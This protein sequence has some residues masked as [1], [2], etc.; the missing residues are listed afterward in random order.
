LYRD[1]FIYNNDN[2]IYY[3]NRGE[4]TV[5]H[6]SILIL[7]LLLI[8]GPAA[9]LDAVTLRVAVASSNQYITADGQDSATI[10]VTVTDSVGTEI[11]NAG[12]VLTITAPWSL[13][14]TLGATKNDGTFTTTFL[15]TSVSGNA[16]ITAIATGTTSSGIFTSTASYDQVIVGSEPAKSLSFYS[17]AS[18]V[19]S[20]T[21]ITVLVLD[22]SGNPVSS[23]KKVQ[24]VVFNTSA[25][26]DSSLV[27]TL[28]KNVK[29]LSVPLNESGYAAVD[30][31]LST[32]P[33]MNYISVLPP[34][35]L[36]EQLITI[37]GIPNAAPA[38]ITQKVT[39][40]GSPPT[41][42]TGTTSY[43][44]IDYRL[45][46]QW[47]NPSA[48]QN[49]SITVNTGEKMM[50]RSNSD[51][52]ASIGYGPKKS[53]GLYLITAQ[54]VNNPALIVAH[55]LQFVS[56]IPTNMILTASPQSMAS[57]DVKSDSSALVMAKVI[58]NQGNPVPGKTVYFSI[59]SMTTA[60]TQKSGPILAGDTGKT[61]NTNEIKSVSDNS[62]YALATFTPG[63]FI[64]NTKSSQYSFMAEGVAKVRARWMND[65][66]TKTVT[67]DINLSYKNYPYLSV[68]TSV[69]PD[70]VMRNGTVEVSV[71]VRGDGYALKPKPVDVYMVTDRS[72]SMD[73]GSPTKMDQVKVAATS[74]MEK[75]DY[76]V[77]RLGQYS[78][79]GNRYYDDYVTRDQVLT[80]NKHG[81]IS[82][83]ISD[84]EPDGYTPLRYAL[85]QS[86]TDLKTNGNSDSV[87][88][89]VILSD[90]NYNW[91]G[92]P[93][94]R[95][96]PG[97]S[98][99]CDQLS[100][101]SGSCRH[102]S[103]KPWSVDDYSEGT[104]SYHNFTDLS[105]Q[106]Q[107]MSQYARENNIRIY[108]IGYSNSLSDDGQATLRALANTTNGRY[109]YALTQA[110]LINFYAQIAGA[111]KDT[112]GV[113]TTLSMDFLNVDV[114]DEVKDRP[115]VL[116]YMYIDGVSTRIKD[117]DGN[118]RTE[119]SM[120]DW[121]KGRINVTMGT[122]KVN[123][124][125]VVNLTLKVK[126]EGNV[127]L[128]GSNSKVLFEDLNG[129]KGETPLPDTY[130]TSIRE[131]INEGLSTP[132]LT[133]DDLGV[134][135]SSDMKT[136]HLAW[137]VS[138]ENGRD[139]DIDEVI[140][141]APG[142]SDCYSKAAP[143][144]V[145]TGY[146]PSDSITLSDT[147]N[148]DISSLPPG[149]YTVRVTGKAYDTGVASTQNT[150]TITQTVIVPSILIR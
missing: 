135:L 108:A 137:D 124:E 59:Q 1:I 102:Y 109:Y 134:T 45:Y 47:G 19:G 149:A 24:Q 75:F 58:D 5:K 35:P 30:F 68:F 142:N 56:G 62:G 43:F 25:T 32:K 122:I 90:G 81:E 131:G 107:N 115:G 86:I 114:N 73:E 2:K 64:T 89:V 60:N 50:I 42:T 74:F 20:V 113:N 146:P 49:L 7:L 14:D 76:S 110:D 121:N 27:D 139:P 141:V 46:D 26:G 48:D 6:L 83:A 33:G 125:W 72:G 18:T 13:K 100:S 94:A 132:T 63:A 57:L 31:L 12:V 148:V 66:S 17:S 143:D 85:Y 40:S 138:Y 70:T 120:E 61:T 9:A 39:P 128:L 95:G 53:A 92:D 77:D 34:N 105:S 37:Q 103:Y 23:K 111:L 36:P 44:I 119:N 3:K 82:T 117:P 41:L 93:L 79:G 22:K 8:A 52:N 126:Q 150:M 10:T 129:V 145:I 16:T 69:E 29:G 112:A 15:P 51:G 65:D 80:D 104:R 144:R 71:R 98:Q 116:E 101:N 106:N 38:S 21:G 99:V 11:K 55:T 78:F 130:V 96:S 140:E 4:N 133:L 91:Y 88:A 147:A 123:Q 136:A 84:L 127:K 54:A 67:H 28:K 97:Q 87:K 118:V